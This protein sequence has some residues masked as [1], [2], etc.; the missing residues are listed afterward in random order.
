MVNI[1]KQMAM[2]VVIVLVAATATAGQER[3]PVTNSDVVAMI[4]AGLSES[5]IIM[6]IKQGPRE[7][8]TSPTTL[9]EL[10][11]KGATTGI[12]EAMMQT[13]ITADPA[14]AKMVTDNVLLDA[15]ST[16]EPVTDKFILI[17]GTNRVVMKYAILQRAERMGKAAL[18]VMVPFAPMK[19]YMKLE[20]KRSSCRIEQGECSFEFT[21]GSGVQPESSV[22]LIVFDVLKQGR[23]I[24]SSSVSM[25]GASFGFPQRRLVPLS[26]TEI[27]AN[28][29]VPPTGLTRYLT[30]YKAVPK[31]VL[32]PGEYAFML[33]KHAAYDFGVDAVKCKVEIKRP[34]AGR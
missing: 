34:E 15:S 7:F 33:T 25:A 28:K 11:S 2:L 19:T 16:Q 1:Y 10:K 27:P 29:N 18:S 20:G 17:N 32:A 3:K 4:T 6:A 22:A 5:T 13:Q 26:I 12:L 24:E 21:M 31:T 30:R 8:D 23:I 14:P 9:I